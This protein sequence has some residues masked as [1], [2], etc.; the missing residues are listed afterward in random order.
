[1]GI[2]LLVLLFLVLPYSWVWVYLSGDVGVERAVALQADGENVL[3]GSGV[4]QDFV[5][6]KLQLYT[7]VKPK[8]VA[9]GSSRVMQFRGAYFTAPFLNMGGVAGNI[10][11]LRSTLEAMLKVHKPEAIILGLDFW[12]FMPTWNPDPFMEEP[13]TSGSYVYSLET[14]KKPWVWLLTGKISGRDLAAPLLQLF[15]LGFRANRLG[16]MAQ[17][18]DDGFAKDGSWYYTAELTG[19]KRPFDFQFEDTFTQ[20]EYGMKAFYHVQSTMAPHETHLAALSEIYCR[21]QALG[22]KTYVFLP[23]LAERIFLRLQK[24]EDKYP[25]LFTLAQ[26][27][28]AR[29]IQVLDLSDPRKL[30]SGDC[31][32]VDGFHGG[33]VTYM[34]ILRHLADQWAS[35]VQYVDMTALNKAIREWKGHAMSFDTNITSVGEVDFMEWGCPKKP[36][37]GL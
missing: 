24:L 35:L 15:G 32:F 31:E 7:Q 5:D 13:P 25:H 3:F 20:I 26:A 23:P 8:I 18:T 22:I 37:R 10:P 33:E 12:W 28:K 30:A 36:G 27:L 4:S 29:G 21:L 34:R 11:V 6:Y 19:Q 14:L 2:S 17:Q 1:M 9:L 16:I